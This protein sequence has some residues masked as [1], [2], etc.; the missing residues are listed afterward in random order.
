MREA[1]PPGARSHWRY[2]TEVQRAAPVAV[3]TASSPAPSW[4][5]LPAGWTLAPGREGGRATGWRWLSLMLKGPTACGAWLNCVSIWVTGSW[6]RRRRME[7]WCAASDPLLGLSWRGGR[8]L[9]VMNG[10]HARGL[11][12]GKVEAK[13]VLHPGEG[14]RGQAEA[15]H[16]VGVDGGKLWDARV[17]GGLRSRGTT[18]GGEGQLFSWQPFCKCTLVIFTQIYRNFQTISR[19]IFS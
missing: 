15:A 3:A 16:V 5:S 17:G 6:W 9:R 11:E 14:G 2:N 18:A 4:A 1:E 10:G 13:F 7:E 8:R 12:L 19:T